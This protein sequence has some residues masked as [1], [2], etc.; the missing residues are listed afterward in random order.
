MPTLKLFWNFFRS[1]NVL[2][3]S[4]FMIDCF[5]AS[6]RSRSVPTNWRNWSTTV[7]GGAFCG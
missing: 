1:A 7:G 6:T 4:C 2:S 3:R 5:F